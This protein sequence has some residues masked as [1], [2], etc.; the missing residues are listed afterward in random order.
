LNQILQVDA[1]DPSEAFEI[2]A[3]RQQ[4]YMPLEPEFILLPSFIF[5]NVLRLEI[6]KT[7]KTSQ[8]IAG[9]SKVTKKS[10][11]LKSTSDTKLNSHKFNEIEMSRRYS[12]EN[13]FIPKT[14]EDSKIILRMMDRCSSRFAIMCHYLMERKGLM[15]MMHGDRPGSSRCD[16]NLYRP[17][18]Q[19]IEEMLS[20]LEKLD[21]IENIKTD[22]PHS[23][24]RR[25]RSVE[26]SNVRYGIN[27]QE[28]SSQEISSEISTFF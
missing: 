22:T 18:Q 5:G 14:K 12:Q 16:E 3:S 15:R 20:G 10:P 24:K 25:A 27:S 4:D 19:E 9:P 8:D 21:V 17:R 23:F 28:I 11:L 13:Y 7:I 6:I 26:I 1:Q 2:F